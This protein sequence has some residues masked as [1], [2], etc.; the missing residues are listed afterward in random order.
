MLE[1][2]GLLAPILTVE[3][4]LD[5]ARR[6]TGLAEYGDL[7]FLTGLAKFLEAVQA[8][9]SL[10]LIGRI[11]CRQMVLTYLRNR[12]LIEESY[13]V[14]PNV[15]EDSILSPLV[16]TGLPRSG[17]TLLFNLLAQDPFLRAP[18]GW[19]LEEPCAILGRESSRGDR[20]LLARKAFGRLERVIPDFKIIHEFG[21]E[22]PQECVAIFGHQFA[23]AQF[24][25]LF[26]VPSY[27]TW[28]EGQAARA[29]YDFHRRFLGVLQ[30]G[31][32][33]RR[34]VLKSPAHLPIIA[35]LFDEYPDACLIQMH[36]DPVKAVPSFAS[37]SFALRTI[38]S[39]SVDPHV[40]GAQQKELWRLSAER[41]MAARVRLDRT[42]RCLDLSYEDL[43]ADPMAAV[44]RLYQ[45]FE[46][47]LRSMAAERMRALLRA[48]PQ[49]EHGVHEYSP[50]QFGLTAADLRRDF[51]E[52][53]ACF[54][55]REEP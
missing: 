47:E 5:S 3:G 36:R 42:H 34:W 21:A 30:R 26:N 32:P 8:E 15:S 11:M 41:G 16:I 24:L 20:V 2:S 22:L 43:V 18:L 1:R 25:T 12:L 44:E 50:G 7:G 52:Y 51:A 28:F 48:H 31:M 27:Q 53:I 38:G 29:T 39:D 14:D 37:F 40:V 19:E 17:T 46:M 13:R 49:H 54:D 6:A 45:H 4:L 33:Q 55:I 9:G 35:E 23:S 10:N